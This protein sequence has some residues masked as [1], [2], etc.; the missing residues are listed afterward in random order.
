MGNAGEAG[1][2]CHT[3]Y[4]LQTPIMAKGIGNGC[5]LLDLMLFISL[6]YIQ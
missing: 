3:A 1:R 6:Y 2:I 5:L 4:G